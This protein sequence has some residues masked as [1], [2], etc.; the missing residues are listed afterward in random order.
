MRL[1]DLEYQQFKLKFH[2]GASPEEGF[3]FP[4]EVEAPDGGSFWLVYV[5]S[6]RFHEALD[7]V[8]RLRADALKP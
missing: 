2:C 3:A 8:T 6:L 7:W 1:T 5:S 4:F